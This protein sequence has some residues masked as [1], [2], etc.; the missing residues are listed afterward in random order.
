VVGAGPAGLSFAA[1]AAARGHDVT[2]FEQ[3]DRIGGQLNMAV[4]VPGKADFN[5]TLRY[6]GRKIERH[7]VQLRL[8][9]RPTADSLLSENYDDIVV[10][11]GV[12]PRIV[13]IP[14]GDHPMVLTYIDVLARKKEVGQRVAIIGAGGIG[15][16]VAEYLTHEKTADDRTGSG[17]LNQWG[18]DRSYRSRGGIS[19]GGVQIPVSRR[20]V[21][22]LQ[23][24]PD[25]MG[26]RLGKTTGWILRLTLKYRGV[27]MIKGVTYRRIDDRGLHITV[28]NENRVL[29][30]ENV[31]ICA[32]QE[33]SRHLYDDLA[34][35]QAP[36]HLIGGADRAGGLDAQRAIEQG[37]RLATRI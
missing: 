7:G 14:G 26:S 30:V 12:V 2:L 10:S 31:I 21:Y 6:F 24:S 29:D 23:R 27:Q 17:F 22:L 16:D 8:N 13:D 18:I 5:E 34:G 4:Q 33:S 9:S 19:A 25:K 35:N 37:V 1:T 28:N 11:T 15:F 32:G 20:Q 36:I 3:T